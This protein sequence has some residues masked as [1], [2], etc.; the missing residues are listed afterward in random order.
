[1]LIF[2]PAVLRLVVRFLLFYPFCLFA[3][4]YLINGHL[5][6]PAYNPCLCGYGYGLSMVSYSFFFKLD[7]VDQFH[8]LKTTCHSVDLVSRLRILF[9][10]LDFCFYLEVLYPRSVF[11]C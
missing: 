5:F 7:W 11:S 3:N 8:D 4:F 10:F 1:M 6:S 9:C 2:R